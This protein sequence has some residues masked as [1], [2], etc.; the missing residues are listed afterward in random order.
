M[1]PRT[2]LIL[3]KLVNSGFCESVNGCVST[4]KEANVYHAKVRDVA[5]RP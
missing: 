5:A 2:R 1:D 3:F 4:G